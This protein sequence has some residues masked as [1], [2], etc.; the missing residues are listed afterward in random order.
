MDPVLLV[1]IISGGSAIVA[2]VGAQIIGARTARRHEKDRKAWERERLAMELESAQRSR[3]EDVKREAYVSYLQAA[4]TLSRQLLAYSSM[5]SPSLIVRFAKLKSTFYENVRVVID[6]GYEIQLLAPELNSQV[7]AIRVHLAKWFPDARKFN[8]NIQDWRTEF[9]SLL[10]EMRTAMQ[11][12]LGIEFDPTRALY[13]D[14]TKRG[15]NEWRYQ[16]N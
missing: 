8:G 13:S 1:G 11:D 6:R 2:S 9:I 10:G 15:P 5:R 4:Y 7:R 14:S 16:V 3:F 12:S